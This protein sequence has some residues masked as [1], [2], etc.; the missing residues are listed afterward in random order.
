MSELYS[1]SSKRS[2][3]AEVPREVGITGEEPKE[4][5]VTGYEGNVPL[6]RVDERTA[7][8]AGEGEGEGQD[9]GVLKF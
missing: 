5:V 4:Q 2:G 6:E 1:K 9:G 7:K 8:R 3:D